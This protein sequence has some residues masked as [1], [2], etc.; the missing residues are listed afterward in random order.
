M[1]TPDSPERPASSPAGMSDYLKEAFLFRWNMLLFVG[2]AAAAAISPI[3]DV[4]LPLVAIG[5][6]TYLTGLV[7]MPRF[8]AAIDAK[9]HA[10]SRVGSGQPTAA[11]PPPLPLAVLLG[12]LP[13]EARTRFERLHS[14]CLE[15]RGIAAGV[16][17]AAGIRPDPRKR[18]AHP[19]WI[20]CCGSSC[21]CCCQKPPSIAFCGR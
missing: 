15:M 4:L 9:A 16:R 17:G 3:P 6:V 10:A 2:A 18:S 14:R 11:A 5:E 21:G 19:A 1:P 7:S 8:R 12:G 20:G 13:E